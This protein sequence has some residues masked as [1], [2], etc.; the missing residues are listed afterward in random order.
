MLNPLHSGAGAEKALLA[1]RNLLTK[2]EFRPHLCIFRRAGG[3][4][5]QPRWA[6]KAALK[7]PASCSPSLFSP[8][9]IPIFR[10][11]RRVKKKVGFE[12]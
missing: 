6:P 1:T 7:R 5:R 11:K 9:L 8:S 12:D 3:Q 10:G 2:R 4:A